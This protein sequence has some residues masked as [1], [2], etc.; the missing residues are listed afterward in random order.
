MVLI[1]HLSDATEFKTSLVFNSSKYMLPDSCAT[2]A[3]SVDV[4]DNH[5][6]VQ[7]CDGLMTVLSHH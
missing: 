4:V 5:L 1:E 6:V 2:G 3:R 7:T